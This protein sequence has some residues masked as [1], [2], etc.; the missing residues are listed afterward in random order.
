MCLSILLGLL[1]VT[2]AGHWREDSRCGQDLVKVLELL[3]G[4]LFVAIRDWPVIDFI[5]VGESVDDEGSQEDGVRDLVAF[6]R[7]AC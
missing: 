3:A 4:S 1:V 6:N 2:L 7:K 5:D